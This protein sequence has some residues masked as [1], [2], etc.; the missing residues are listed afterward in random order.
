MKKTQKP[1]NQVQKILFSQIESLLPKHTI[2]AHEIADVLSLSTDSVYRRMRGEKKLSIDEICTLCE[3]FNISVDVLLNHKQNNISFET[4]P[5]YS[6]ELDNFLSHLD[7][8]GKTFKRYQPIKNKKIL[9]LAAEIPFVHLA[10]FEE[11][12]TFKIYA[13]ANSVSNYSGN[14]ASF[15]S[16]VKGDKLFS[17]YKEISNY[18]DQIPSLEI[19]NTNTYDAILGWI[20]Y[21][22]ESGNLENKEMAIELCV[23]LMQLT[24]ELQAKIDK[25]NENGQ[26]S[27]YTFYICDVAL[28]NN[29]MIIKSDSLQ[30]CFLRLFSA[31]GMIVHDQAYCQET[32]KWFYNLHDKSTLVSGSSKKERHIFFQVLKNKVQQ[33]IDKLNYQN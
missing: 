14:Y 21:Y 26:A 25:G 11:L 8:L 17:Y 32:E 7:T 1:V 22:Y 27:D 33:L 16:L 12:A 13:W 4:I 18:Y 24:T 31:S 29:F 10:A 19:W 28:E 20:E 9:Y 3:H 2:P 5:F 30:D 23:Q 15:C 6:D